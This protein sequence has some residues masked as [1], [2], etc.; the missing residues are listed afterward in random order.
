MSNI[1]IIN[2]IFFG[3]VDFNASY[4]F[5][6]ILVFDVLHDIPGELTIMFDR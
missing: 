4:V 1:A 2:E 3:R 5:A 6:K